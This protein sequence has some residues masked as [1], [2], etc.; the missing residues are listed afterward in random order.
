MSAPH[1]DRGPTTRARETT[2]VSFGVSPSTGTAA[3]ADTVSIP[4]TTFANAVY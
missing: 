2:I 3:I 1:C 4:D